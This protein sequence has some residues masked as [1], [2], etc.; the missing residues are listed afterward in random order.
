MIKL[1]DL[2]ENKIIR[3]GRKNELGDELVIFPGK[4]DKDLPGWY[5]G[6][7]YFHAG[8]WKITTLEFF[9]KKSQA[10][11]GLKHSSLRKYE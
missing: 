1:K 10:I 9:E 4:S 7:R 2:L 3:T 5:I 6:E 8:K 11:K